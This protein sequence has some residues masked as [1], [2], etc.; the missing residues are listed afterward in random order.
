MPARRRAAADATRLIAAGAVG[1]RRSQSGKKGVVKEGA[2]ARGLGALSERA[3]HFK[4]RAAPSQ[5]GPA[6][7]E[8]DWTQLA[9]TGTCAPTTIT[10]TN[11][12]PTAAEMNCQLSYSTPVLILPLSKAWSR[13]EG[14]RP[15]RIL[16]R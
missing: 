3:A 13:K 7:Q 4:K 15:A 14:G 16:E 11:A 9:R 5:P 1:R 12:P 2:S 6:E 8:V 10:R